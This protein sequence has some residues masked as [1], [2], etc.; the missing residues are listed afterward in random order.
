MHTTSSWAQKHEE[1]KAQAGSSLRCCAKKR[2]KIVDARRQIRYGPR[3][4]IPECRRTRSIFRD[5]A[6]I[7][8]CRGCQRD[9]VFASS[10]S[11]AC[12]RKISAIFMPIPERKLL[13]EARRSGIC[14]RSYSRAHVRNHEKPWRD[15]PFSSLHEAI[16]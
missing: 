13:K 11:S 3:V 16:R 1:Q 6:Q 9:S 15:K 7:S 2:W 12:L 14:R 10:S 4:R 8:Q 5:V